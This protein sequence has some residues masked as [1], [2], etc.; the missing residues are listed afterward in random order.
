M[1][2]TVDRLRHLLHQS[3]VLLTRKLFGKFPD[4]H[5][6]A[7]TL[8][9]L[10]LRRGKKEIHKNITVNVNLCHFLLLVLKSL[11]A[12]E[13][14]KMQQKTSCCQQQ[15]AF[16]FHS[17]KTKPIPLV[18]DGNS[19]LFPSFKSSTRDQTCFPDFPAV[20]DMLKYIP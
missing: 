20:A 17:E 11:A 1:E 10:N 6:S 5:G 8:F 4:F 9:Y 13:I 18:A 2:P 16:I 12:L 7:K 15:Q 14:N 3:N 19:L